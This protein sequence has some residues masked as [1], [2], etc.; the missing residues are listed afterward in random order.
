[1]N[2]RT[3][4]AEQQARMLTQAVSQSR[5]ALCLTDP[6]QTDNPIVYVNAAFLE[7]TGYDE[8][9]ILGRNCRFLQ[10]PETD[11]H[12]VARVRHALDKRR[13]TIV[14]LLNYRKDGSRFVNALQIGPIFDSSGRLSY[15]FGSQMDVTEDRAMEARAKQL[16]EE[17]LRH[18]LTNVMSVLEILVRLTA[19]ENR[20]AASQADRIAERVRA[21]GEAHLHTLVTGEKRA[22]LTVVVER[23]LRAYAPHGSRSYRLGG[24]AATLGTA[25]ISP[26][27]LLLHELASNA[28]KHG[29][30]G[31]PEGVVTV[32]W[33][34]EPSADVPG[35]RM[36]ML[37]WREAGGLETTAP[38]RRSGS[39][40]V[41][42]LLTLAHGQLDFDWRPEGLVARVRLP[43]G[44]AA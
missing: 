18:R 19:R 39:R 6:G 21:V 44:G 30:L 7:L 11:P 16:A 23:V 12:A 43:V 14:E 38:L 35:Q 26:L 24:P 2:E 41:T 10:G 22:D 28:I 33:S 31:Q 4:G 37:E 8:G 13:V 32:A 42:E 3:G 15:F 9:E 34:L 20:D 25:S 29:A 17:E 27:V 40:I 36:L 1:M 5:L